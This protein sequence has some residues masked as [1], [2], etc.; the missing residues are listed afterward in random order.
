MFRMKIE[1]SQTVRWR[2]GGFQ[3]CVL[4]FLIE[5]ANWRW[6]GSRF[7]MTANTFQVSRTEPDLKEMLK[8]LEMS[9]E[10]NGKRD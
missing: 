6:N 5:R 7:D 3:H 9:G 2:F 1:M 4:E 8:I 10:K